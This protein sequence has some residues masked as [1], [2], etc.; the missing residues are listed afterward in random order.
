M[1][2]N[3]GLQVR[4][5]GT[6]SFHCNGFVYFSDDS[7]EGRCEHNQS[8]ERFSNNSRSNQRPQNGSAIL[9]DDGVY[10][11][12]VMVNKTL[13]LLGADK[14]DAVVDGSGSGDVIEITADNVVFDGFT[15]RKSGFE[16]VGVRLIN[17]NGSILMGNIITLNSFAGV[18]LDNSFNSTSLRLHRV[19][20]NRGK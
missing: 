15:V 20:D 12:H 8:S 18:L 13:T 3:F 14:E 4:R 10:Y 11:E 1:E 7:D 6:F 16:G 9:V 5:D 17:S 19:I 2:E